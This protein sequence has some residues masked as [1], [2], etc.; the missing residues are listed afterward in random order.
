MSR[1][2]W[3]GLGL[4]PESMMTGATGS[5]DFRVAGSTSVVGT[6]GSDMTV[7]GTGPT[8]D[9]TMSSLADFRRSHSTD[10]ELVDH[11]NLGPGGTDVVDTED[12]IRQEAERCAPQIAEHGTCC[13]VGTTFFDDP[14]RGAICAKAFGSCPDD[15]RVVPYDPDQ[16][17]NVEVAC[18]GM[19]KQKCLD[20]GGVWDMAGHACTDFDRPPVEVAKKFPTML[21]VGGAAAALLLV[22]MLRR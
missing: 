3:R 18:Y 19:A 6:P 14:D 11:G 9:S 8:D 4:L 17:F 10:I 7:A 13:P 16:G 21:V 15:G 1:E 5:V 2:Y 22:F 20:T 12:L